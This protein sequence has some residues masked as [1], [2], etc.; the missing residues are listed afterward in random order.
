MA[1]VQSKDEG[2]VQSSDGAPGPQTTSSRNASRNVTPRGALY[3]DLSEAFRKIKGKQTQ[4][5]ESNAS[6]GAVA[7]TTE[8]IHSAPGNTPKD[9][10]SSPPEHQQRG[11]PQPAD[12]DSLPGAAKHISTGT[13]KRDFRFPD[14][15]PSKPVASMPGN[16]SGDIGQKVSGSNS[17]GNTVEKIYHHYATDGGDT[18]GYPKIGTVPIAQSGA[19]TQSYHRRQHHLDIGPLS[20]NP[21]ESPLPGIPQSRRNSKSFFGVTDDSSHVAESTV[22]DSQ[23]LLNADAQTGEHQQAREPLFPPP[24]RLPSK[25]SK[26]PESDGRE[27]EFEEIWSSVQ[28]TTNGSN[29]D[30]FRY[31]GG[32]YRAAMLP[33]R[34]EEVSQAL[35][36]WSRVGGESEGT[37]GTLQSSPALN[38]T[39]TGLGRSLT[40]RAHDS[41]AVTGR[42]P[43]DIKI[44]ISDRHHL[45]DVDQNGGPSK[46]SGWT[47]NARSTGG[48][49]DWCTETSSEFVHHSG[50]LPKQES[51][52]KITGSSIADCL[53]DEDKQGNFS[54]LPSTRRILQHP[55]ARPQPDSYE[56]HTIKGMKQP[57]SLPNSN[58]NQFPNNSTRFMPRSTKEDSHAQPFAGKLA[59]PFGRGDDSYRRADRN[60]NFTFKLDR[61]GSTRYEFRDSTASIT[62]FQPPPAAK[63][64][65]DSKTASRLDT[66]DAKKR[67][68]RPDSLDFLSTIASNDREFS[69]TKV[70]ATP[71][72]PHRKIRLVDQ[73]YPNRY[74]K[75]WTAAQEQPRRRAATT[76]GQSAVNEMPVAVK[77][78]FKFDL[79]PLGEAQRKNKKDRESGEIDETAPGRVRYQR[80]L[81]SPSSPNFPT[82][83][84]MSPP[85][86]VH[87]R[88]RR[89][90]GFE[91][92]N[93][94]PSESPFGGAFNET[95]SPFSAASTHAFTPT[96]NLPTRLLLPHG[97]SPLSPTEN[98]N[99]DKSKKRSWFE[100][101]GRDTF[102][103]KKQCRGE[104]GLQNVDQAEHRT[105]NQAVDQAVDRAVDNDPLP[106]A[107]SGLS[108]AAME[109]VFESGLSARARHQ[110]AQFF[111]V[112]ATLSII[113][114][115]FAIVVLAGG[116]NDCLRWW[117][118][119]EVHHLALSQRNFIRNTFLAEACVYIFL[120]ASL[121]AVYTKRH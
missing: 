38:H 63:V 66:E 1:P 87:Q 103:S 23:H 45:E 99:T 65:E 58:M 28:D 84:P 22:T 76:G 92:S 77:S 121:I 53:D 57:V 21:P 36:R 114:P 106:D 34:E 64:T 118:K 94:S 40:G 43:R 54:G 75:C 68:S 4:A 60:D 44:F 35:R 20:S 41:A 37:L 93:L 33:D 110:R 47:S 108:V 26:K 24:L 96:S 14:I 95:P 85:M 8:H 109:A 82:S 112:V 62:G 100:R 88:N 120:V 74:A 59:N 104:S 119:G 17:S 6:Q 69:S 31:D 46:Q 67:V 50:G 18:T 7:P 52:F 111:Y 5:P 97:S 70:E 72:A 10:S 105:V 83:N 12:R 15:E 91:L 13:L 116:L 27:D 3:D 48:D 78:K 32:H 25:K 71:P 81:S 56:V 73:D 11:T 79:L 2:V 89:E 107:E 117:T 16:S 80:V 90:I 30:P 55:G 113:M 98:T 49:G 9:S 29:D 102:A 51:T 101:Y 39:S 61:K 115:F 42:E 19:P 86:P